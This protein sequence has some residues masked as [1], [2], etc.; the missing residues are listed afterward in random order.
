M[1]ASTEIAEIIRDLEKEKSDLKLDNELLKRLNIALKVAE[2]KNAILN[3]IIECSDDAI[4]SKDLESIVTSW[5]EAAVRIFGYKPEEMIGQSIIK[6]IPTDRHD[7]EPKILSQLKSGIRV[8]HFETVRMKKDGTLIHVSL[9]ISPIKDGSGKVIGLSK[10]A[11]D[12]TERKQTET[13]KD[14]FIGFVSHELKTP[15][16]SLRS[17]IQVALHKAR[18]EKQAQISHALSRAEFQTKKMESIITDFLNISRLEDGHMKL[19]M[20]SFD[21]APL[22]RNCMADAAITSSKH[23][24]IYDGE[25]EALA[26]GDAEKIALVL[27]NLISN[28]QKYSPQGGPIAISCTKQ[29]DT[30]LIGIKDN[31]IGIS[32]EDQK[33]M[34][35]KFYRITSEQTKLISGFGI[36]LYLASSIM[37]LHGSKITVES[38]LGKG[39]I[40]TF[41]IKA[42]K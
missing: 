18:G 20:D 30:F 24:L 8:D 11:R 27:T 32:V 16:T 15:L 23:E 6:I 14:E 28:A 3:S 4:I 26:Y 12:I 37:E 25:E 40:F 19:E 29:D 10:I 33:N 22:I 13:K 21:L 36:G 41:E 42:K 1:K 9:T 5:N 31:G 34:F 7:E 39:S 38:D 2:E 17:Y 35:Q